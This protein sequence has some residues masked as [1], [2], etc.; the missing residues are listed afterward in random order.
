MS[1]FVLVMPNTL[2]RAFEFIDALLAQ[3]WALPIDCEVLKALY[4]LGW[5]DG[6][7]TGSVDVLSRSIGVSAPRLAASIEALDRRHAVQAREAGGDAIAIE[8]VCMSKPWVV[9]D[10]GLGWWRYF[11]VDDDPGAEIDGDSAA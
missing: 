5:D 11:V 10:T 1:Q 2:S 6:F 3:G 4:A 9:G 7:V 8:L